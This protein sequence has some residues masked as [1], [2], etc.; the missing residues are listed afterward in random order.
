MKLILRVFHGL[1]L[2]VGINSDSVSFL[3]DDHSSNRT[4]SNVTEINVKNVDV[5]RQLLNQETLIRMTM[6]KNVHSL[7]KDML[8]LQENLAKTDNKIT[9]IQTST[10]Q[11]ILELKKQVEWL[12]RENDDLKNKSVVQ[13]DEIIQLK[14]TLKNVNNTLTEMKIEVRYLSIALFGMDT[15]SK[16]ID[17]GLQELKNWTRKIEFEMMENVTNYAAV[18]SDLDRKHLEYIDKINDT[19]ILLKS[20]IDQYEIDQLKMAAAVSSLEL[21]RI[22]QTQSKCDVSTRIGFTAGVTSSSD[23]WN[24]GT[25]VFPK[26]ITN[27][28]NGYNPS[29]GVFT[30]PMAGVYVFFVNVQSYDTMTIYVDI[31]L[32]GAT[33]VRTMAYSQGGHGYEEAGPNL[34]VLSLQTGYRVWVKHHH[35]RG[36]FTHS[37]NPITTFSGFLI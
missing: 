24:S 14:E 15:H 6:V 32:N 25:L 18:I 9:G 16:E 10:D 23:S 19:T 3:T 5:F 22:N 13:N 1:V 2:I 28:G 37:D 8:T 30:A 34:A 35:G 12:K 33:K 21:F 20:D 27:V 36:Y 17:K 29:D 31:V 4:N 26:V 11:E 7:M